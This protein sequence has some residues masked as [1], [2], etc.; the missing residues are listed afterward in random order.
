MRF[1]DLAFAGHAVILSLIIITQYSKRVWGFEKGRL[2]ERRIS[3]G[4]WGILVGSVFVTGVVA[5][6]VL[7]S[8]DEDPVEGWA[9]IDV[10]SSS[11]WQ[12]SWFPCC[13][14]RSKEVVVQ[15]CKTRKG[16]SVPTYRF[17][18]KPNDHRKLTCF[19]PPDLHPLHR[20]TR[21]NLRQIHPASPQQPPQ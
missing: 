13:A 9:W 19:K 15:G 11:S 8:G 20:Q 21:H 18:R 7:F 6:V 3:K 10:V 14:T 1:N 5:L 4:I 12:I 17:A 2:A 16:I